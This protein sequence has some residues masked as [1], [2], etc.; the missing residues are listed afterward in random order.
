MFTTG[1]TQ[2]ALDAIANDR[3]VWETF[4]EATS[5]D[6]DATRCDLLNASV[7]AAFIALHEM[8][9]YFWEAANDTALEFLGSG[10]A[11]DENPWEGTE[12][13]W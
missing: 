3:A 6:R 13:T 8:N 10:S 9:V 7:E 5:A 2:Y 12:T 4:P 11:Y 1:I